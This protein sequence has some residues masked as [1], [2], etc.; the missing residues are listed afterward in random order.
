LISRTVRRVSQA[1][2]VTAVVAGGVT[3][4][5]VDKAVTLSVDG[6]SSAVHVLGSHVSDVLAKEHI[7]V[8]SHD[9]VS[10]APSAGIADGQTVVVRYGRLLSVTVDG[11]RKS[12]W[13]TATTVQAALD[14]IGVRDANATLSVSRSQP[15]GRAGLALSV[16]T[17]K[18][19]TITADHK[20]RRI[21][22]TGLTVQDAL[23][24]AG[25]TLGKSDRV[26]PGVGSP[27]VRSG[28][29]VT[30]QRVV[31]KASTTHQVLAHGTVHRSTSS[32]YDGQT[33][34]VTHGRDGSK[35][36]TY[37]DTWVDGKRTAHT[38]KSSHVTSEPVSTVV[39]VGTKAVVVHHAAARPTPAVSHSSSS[40][41]SSSSSGG[42]HASSDGLNWA[43]LARCESGGNPRAVNPSGYYGL[44]QFSL[45]TWAGVGGSGNPI[46][47]SSGEQ[48]Y[49][50]QILYKRTGA[51]S[52]PVCGRQL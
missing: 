9:L 38:L 16:T 28:M 36:I 46:N 10:P 29:H 32:L 5:A 17:P 22:T 52:W 40:S 20:N 25:I 18:S 26:S 47:A 8:G 44:Y 34:T 23:N 12:Y 13:T 6:K 14:E 15:L 19:V 27:I 33:R 11:V 7:S 24:Q 42:H 1:A 45:S 3:Y 39:E 37:A 41:S 50:A 48:T 4:A 49:R 35:V 21:T 30:V 2:A 51:S 43:A 31:L